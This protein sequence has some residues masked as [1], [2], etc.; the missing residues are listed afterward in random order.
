M[1]TYDDKPWLQKYDAYVPHTLEPYPDWT[2]GDLLSQA[3][4]EIPNTPA[5][6]MS[7]HVPVAGR[8]GKTTTYAELKRQ[9]DAFGAA[10]LGL[11]LQKG[12]RVALLMPNCTAFVV[13]W[14]GALSAG[15]VAVGINPTYP[16]ARLAEMLQDSGTK[17]IVT[18]S[19][20]YRSVQQIRSETPLKQVIV[21][22]I[23][24]GFPGLAAFLFGIAKEKKGGHRVKL[25]AGDHWLPD[26][27]AKY[28]GQKPNV[29]VTKDDIAIFQYTGGTTGPSKAAVG[30]HGG[31]VANTLQQ[32]A[33]LTGKEKLESG[34]VILAAI[35][36]YH[37]Y[38][39]ISVIATSVTTRATM[40]IVINAR[41]AHE[42]LDVI[43]TYRPRIFHGVPA[44]YNMINMHPDV[45]SGKSD[46]S[47]IE[48]CLSGSAPL[49]RPTK[50]MFEKQSGGKLIEA[51]GMSEAPTATHANPLRGENRTGSVGLPLTDTLCR[52]VSAE[53]PQQVLPVGEIGEI[54]ISGPQLMRGYHERPTET[55][56][57]LIEDANGRRWLL[58]G[59]LGY[60]SEDGYFFIVDR[61]KDMALIGGFNVYPNQVDQVLNA[62]PAVAEVAV[63]VIPH[64][65]KAGQEALK[66]WVVTKSGQTVTPEE[67][68]EF[69]GKKLARY[70]IP[71]RYE[72]VEALP[73]TAVGKILRRELVQQEIARR[74]AEEKS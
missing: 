9:A 38:G 50:E 52:I 27:L 45:Q 33:W 20:Y 34:R 14:Y 74:D 19:L 29:S 67:L 64:P 7:A 36:F 59:D 53:D 61:K 43:R 35:P 42:L 28:D 17:A 44:L 10:L 11:G 25:A 70:E 56:N 22:N 30:T 63:G 47:S 48:L 58:T 16:P 41:D 13:A 2:L 26:L 8:I 66:A 12:D 55:Q 72:F 23:K 4:K 15:M 62:H 49:P 71:S 6:I 5:V 1:V 3:A 54:A 68:M 69:A 31:I 40:A 57:V 51:Y 39:M 18:L 60:M 65:E 37:V 24:E 46:L 32:N 73:R 21:T